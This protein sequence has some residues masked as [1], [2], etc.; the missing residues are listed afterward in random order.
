MRFG[1]NDVPATGES[2]RA[3]AEGQLSGMAMY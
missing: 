3:T 2:V 1:G